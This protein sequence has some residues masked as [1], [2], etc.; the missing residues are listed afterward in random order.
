MLL[1]QMDNKY[2]HNPPLFILLLS[3]YLINKRRE[4]ARRFHYAWIPHRIRAVVHSKQFNWS[5]VFARLPK[6]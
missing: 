3:L 2:N 4:H 1:M 5:L 6:M